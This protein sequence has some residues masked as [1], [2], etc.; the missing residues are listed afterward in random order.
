ME[1]LTSA[2]PLI[3]KNVSRFSNQHLHLLVVGA[4]KVFLKLLGAKNGQNN[5]F[6]KIY[7]QN[8]LT[9]EPLMYSY[10]DFAKHKGF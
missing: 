5:L 6:G 8:V 3:Q 7:L 4:A 1:K 9:L 2:Q 10:E